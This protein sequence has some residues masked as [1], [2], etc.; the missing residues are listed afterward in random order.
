MQHQQLKPTPRFDQLNGEII[1]PTNGIKQ[2]LHG[3]WTLPMRE[4][5]FRRGD[6]EERSVFIYRARVSIS[7]IHLEQNGIPF[8]P[9][10]R[11]QIAIELDQGVVLITLNRELLLPI[12]NREMLDYPWDVDLRVYPRSKAA[13]NRKIHLTELPRFDDRQPSSEEFEKLFDPESPSELNCLRIVA[14]LCVF[15]F[16]DEADEEFEV[17]LGGADSGAM[18]SYQ[19]EAIAAC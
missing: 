1:T 14:D 19:E 5:R 9:I 8:D 10:H 4:L 15:D 12:A 7:E 2:K 16:W 3:Q 11:T 18:F 13:F 6:G 17:F